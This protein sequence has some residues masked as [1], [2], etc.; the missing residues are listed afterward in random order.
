MNSDAKQ[1]R[2]CWSCEYYESGA[3]HRY[4]VTVA[5]SLFDVRHPVV[6]HNDWCGEWENREELVKLMEKVIDYGQD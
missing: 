1:E 6:E 2:A 4:P 5:V 3:C